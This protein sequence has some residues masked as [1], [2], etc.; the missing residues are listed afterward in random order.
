MNGKPTP[1]VAEKLDDT[2]LYL[3]PLGFL[4]RL[5]SDA[6]AGVDQLNEA[7]ADEWGLVPAEL[8]DRALVDI[9]LLAVATDTAPTS[10]APSS[11]AALELP[12]QPADRHPQPQQRGWVPL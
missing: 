4:N 5:P 1:A 11:R 10:L 12:V 6:A 9:D 2:I 3:Q 7:I 8:T